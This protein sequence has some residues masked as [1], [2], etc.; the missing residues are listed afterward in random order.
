MFT[1]MTYIDSGFPWLSNYSHQQKSSHQ[2]NKRIKSANKWKKCAFWFIR[3]QTKAMERVVSLDLSYSAIHFV[4]WS[5]RW[6]QTK[7]C[8]RDRWV[9]KVSIGIDN[10][11]LLS[12]FDIKK[13]KGDNIAIALLLEY[14]MGSTQQQLITMQRSTLF[15]LL[16]H[17]STSA[18]RLPFDSFRI[19]VLCSLFVPVWL[20]I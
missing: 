11:F 2:T 10:R 13:N 14:G 4:I 20:F 7:I 17:V 12:S 18:K 16:K 8:E 3:R 6:E 19:P 15:C 5:L 9:L 1:V